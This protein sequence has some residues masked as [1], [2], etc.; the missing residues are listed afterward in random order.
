MKKMLIS[1]TVVLIA[2][3][4]LTACGERK[5]TADE[6]QRASEAAASRAAIEARN[7]EAGKADAKW[8]NARSILR[9][10]GIT[11]AS[12]GKYS[13]VDNCNVKPDGYRQLQATR[14]FPSSAFEEFR[15]GCTDK[16]SAM[17]AKPK[18]HSNTTAE[19]LARKD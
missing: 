8:L 3:L 4:G 7:V 15:A 1:M 5:F 16:V 12:I 6:V 11:T 18:R 9:Q 19:Q 17:K 10:M 14:D 13:T 2:A